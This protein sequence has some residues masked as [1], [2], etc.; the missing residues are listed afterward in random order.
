MKP[1]NP[2]K[3]EG[4]LMSDAAEKLLKAD[5]EKF[6]S[7][8]N[9]VG[10][11]KGF[12]NCV[13]YHFIPNTIYMMDITPSADLHDVDFT[14]PKEFAFLELAAQAFEAAN[15]RMYK[16]MQTLI[17]RKSTSG[18]LY[19]FRMHRAKLY[20]YFLGSDAAW[21]SFVSGKTIAGVKHK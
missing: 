14:I 17:K 21:N 9:G 13:L 3:Y 10:S 15:M 12:L 19:N 18:M 5:P 7:F 6:A 1:G 11:K 20:Y 2:E 16:N 8:C 4:L